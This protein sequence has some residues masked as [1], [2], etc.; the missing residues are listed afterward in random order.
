MRLPQQGAQYTALL[1]PQGKFLFGFFLVWH[2][3][4]VLLDIHE[5]RAEA[6]LQRLTQYRLRSKVKMEPMPSLAVAASGQALPTMPDIP[7]VYNDP[8]SPLMGMRLIGDRNQIQNLATADMQAYEHKRLSLGMPD[9]FVDMTP[10]KS[11]PLPFRLDKMGAVDFHKG[12]YVGQEVTAR[13]KHLGELRKSIFTVTGNN[14]PAPGEPIFRATYIA[15][16]MLS[17]SDNLGLALLQVAM[18]AENVLFTTQSGEALSASLPSWLKNT[19][20]A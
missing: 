6:L 3:N 2:E 11:F 5:K 12:C 4:A 19:P 20:E 18:V 1:T 13:S 9:E 15:G 10:E 14:L 16:E 17:S 7:L 8:R